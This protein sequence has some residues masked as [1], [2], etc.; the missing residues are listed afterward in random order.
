[1]QPPTNDNNRIMRTLHRSTATAASGKVGKFQYS[2]SLTTVPIHLFHCRHML[3]IHLT[4]CPMLSCGLVCRG[5][6]F[7]VVRFCWRGAPQL[8]N[9]YFFVFSPPRWCTL[10]PQLLLL[11][12]HRHRPDK[13]EWA[14]SATS[15]ELYSVYLNNNKKNCKSDEFKISSHTIF[16]TIPIPQPQLSLFWIKRSSALFCSR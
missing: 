9:K 2:H 4:V 14:A 15:S 12:L 5:L 11:W 10:C 13:K 3:S 6:P 7:A 1:M 8:L 16:N